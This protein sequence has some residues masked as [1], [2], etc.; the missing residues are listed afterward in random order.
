MEAINQNCNQLQQL[1]LSRNSLSADITN[2]SSINFIS[3]LL[4]FIET[5]DSLQHL[6]LEKMTLRSRVN[7]LVGTIYNSKSI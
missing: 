3:Q 5:S 6:N 7:S 1:N 2:V 4:K